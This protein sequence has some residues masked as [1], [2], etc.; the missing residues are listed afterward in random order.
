MI[1]TFKKGNLACVMSLTPVLISCRFP[2]C[3]PHNH[4]FQAVADHEDLLDGPTLFFQIL[5]EVFCYFH[6][7]KLSL[8][9]LL[10][11]ST[12]RN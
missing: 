1:Q 12:V 9:K 5:Q 3:N 8:A 4:S 7:C 11:K 6:F 2:T 10:L